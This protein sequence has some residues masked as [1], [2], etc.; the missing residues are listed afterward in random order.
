MTASHRLADR[1]PA[2]ARPDLP[3]PPTLD[4]LGFASG[5]AA[6]ALYLVGTAVFLAVIIPALPPLGAPAPAR[7]AY[8]AAMHH[9]LLYRVTSFLGQ[10]Q[11]LLLLPFFGALLAVLRREERGEGA[12]SFAVFGA[13]VALALLSPIV[14]M[15]EDHL[16][17][18]LAAAGVDPLVAVSFD[19]L[20]PKSFALGAMPQAIAVGGAA[21]LLRRRCR[22]GR[23]LGW[24]GVAVAALSLVGTGTLVRGALFPVS[25]MAA[26]LARVW[27]L[28]LAVALRP[29]GAALTRAGARRARSWWTGHPRRVVASEQ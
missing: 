2:A 22:I 8:Y 21:V 5:V 28:A 18:G 14:M 19:G 20:V 10:L 1:P 29:R 16:L 3:A 17:L 4:R 6:G 13:G 25:S 15:V 7:A 12:L 11:L 24:S 9:D 27:L 23:A 26:L